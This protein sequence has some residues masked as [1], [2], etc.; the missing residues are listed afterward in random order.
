MQRFLYTLLV[1]F[2][3]TGTKAVLAQPEPG[4]VFREYYWYNRSGNADYALRVSDEGNFDKG[5][6]GGNISTRHVFDL[7]H[8]VKAEVVIEKIQS[9]EGTRDLEISI[10]DN[11]WTRVPEAESIPIAKY[12]YLHHIYPVMEIPLS[13]LNSE[14]DN[15]FRMKVSPVHPWNWPQHLINGIH[16]RIYYDP[17]LKNHPAGEITSP[18]PDTSVGESVT[19]AAE[20]SSPDTVIKQVDFVGLY[21]DVNCSGS[22]LDLQNALEYNQG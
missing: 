10:N 3:I 21:E 4:D 9:H 2:L 1:F 14:S 18:L 11:E 7:E 12:N 19:F 15:K 13:W 5:Y 6:G 20:A 17:E 8:A 16:F 22:V